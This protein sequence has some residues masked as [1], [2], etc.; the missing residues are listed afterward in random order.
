MSSTSI[1]RKERKL[2]FQAI[3]SLSLTLS[4]Y[5]KPGAIHR[6]SIN[7]ERYDNLMLFVFAYETVI[8]EIISLGEAINRGKKSLSDFP[9]S[10]ILSSI[11]YVLHTYS[12]GMEERLVPTLLLSSITDVLHFLV[13]GE[14][15]GDQI[16]IYSSLTGDN[17]KEFFDFIKVY[18]KEAR[19]ILN[20]K[21]YNDSN[22]ID[23]SLLELINILAQAKRRDYEYLLR[24]P[25]SDCV[26]VIERAYMN[27]ETL[28]NS[29]ITGFINLVLQDE[30][31]SSETKNKLQQAL[32]LGGMKTK[33][34]GKTLLEIDKQLTSQAI[35]LNDHLVPLIKCIDRFFFK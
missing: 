13:K 11:K 1:I 35:D 30:K 27:G 29:V 15:G 10:S 23:A 18:D 21:G 6:F 32:K 2:R 17:S 9:L 3:Y 28:N 20:R 24:T 4:S 16:Y 33:E 14:I 7:L 8:D 22:I 31:L 5:I 34:G 25:I 12:P 19:L 26:A